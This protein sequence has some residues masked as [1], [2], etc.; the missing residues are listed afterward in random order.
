MTVADTLEKNA[1]EIRVLFAHRDKKYRYADVR[2]AMDVRDSIVA[3]A[4]SERNQY[5]LHHRVPAAG[6]AGYLY[7]TEAG[8]TLNIVLS[9]LTSTGDGDQF[10]V[11]RG[12]QRVLDQHRAGE[13]IN[14]RRK[15]ARVAVAAA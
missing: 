1:F 9:Y 14:V 13:I 3:W 10:D 4:C 15:R 2:T 11:R 6:H 12:V 7:E 5:A 8:W